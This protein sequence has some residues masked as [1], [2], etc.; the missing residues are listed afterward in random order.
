MNRV[1]NCPIETKDGL[2]LL[3]G[4]ERRLLELQYS[5]GSIVCDTSCRYNCLCEW[6]SYTT[7]ISRGRLQLSVFNAM[8]SS[9]IRQKDESQNRG[10]RK[11]KHCKFSERQTLLTP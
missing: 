11:T 2:C 3:H 1:F 8:L 9:V 10:N 5:R 7:E 6:S 4:R